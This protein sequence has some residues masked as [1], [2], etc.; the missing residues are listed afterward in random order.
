MYSIKQIPEDFIVN[1]AIDVKLSSSGS[2]SYFILKKRDYATPSS[3]EKIAKFLNIPV[4][5]IGYAGAKDRRAVTTQWISVEGL[6]DKAKKFKDNN[7]E[8][9]YK[10]RGDTAI[11]LGRLKGNNFEIVVR[12]IKSKPKKIA[13]FLNLFDE[14]RFSMNNVD[15]GRAIVKKD[16]RKAVE[17]LME[18]NGYYER[19]VKEHYENTNDA[20]NSLRRVSMHV[21]LF[22]I[23]AY[24]SELWNQYAEKLK[25]MKNNI[26]LPI[27]GFGTEIKDTKIRKAIEE[28]MKKED[29][30]YRD[31][32][33]R[34]M[35]ELSSEGSSRKLYGDV[36]KLK[37]GKLENDELNNGMKKIKISFF[38]DKGNYATMVIKNM[39]KGS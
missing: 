31:F 12:N 36:K 32:I 18:N 21:L 30:T 26:N 11:Y 15:I 7:I 6:P 16:F 25:N 38:L 10:G 14:Q 5:R 3:V 35:P 28:V 9:E 29:I 19:L 39:F 2:Y 34:S 33:I 1:E 24:Q 22:F 20:V 8:L 17:T 23:H 4:K 37:I 27:I 13:K